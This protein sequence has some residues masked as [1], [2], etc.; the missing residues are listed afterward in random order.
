[1]WR[2]T[3]ERRRAR[4]R[5]VLAL[6]AVLLSGCGTHVVVAEQFDAGAGA[7]MESD[8][9]LG[10]DAVAFDQ[11]VLTCGHSRCRNHPAM[12]GGVTLN[13]FACCYDAKHSACGVVE[14]DTCFPLDL[15]GRQ[16]DS[17]EPVS[18]MLGYLPGCCTPGGACGSLE[19]TIGIGCV[20]IPLV[21]PLG[22]CK[23]SG[24]P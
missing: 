17:C 2:R 22:K 8:A 18:T 7:T 24:S 21:T 6:F 20:Q 13:G 5:A 4:L 23:F 11:G 19:T 15:P 1:M 10:D 14:I 3:E 12:I 16:D 9:Q